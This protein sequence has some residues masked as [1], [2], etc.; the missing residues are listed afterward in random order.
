[1]ILI[2]TRLYFPETTVWKVFRRLRTARMPST[3]CFSTTCRS[4]KPSI[5]PHSARA[6][7]HGK[8]CLSTPSLHPRWTWM[9]AITV[10]CSTSV[11]A[12]TTKTRAQTIAAASRT[13]ERPFCGWD[14]RR[15]ALRRSHAGDWKRSA[16]RVI[17]WMATRKT[18]RRPRFL[19][20]CGDWLE[21]CERLWDK[22]VLIQTMRKFARVIKQKTETTQVCDMFCIFV[23]SQDIIISLIGKPL[24]LAVGMKWKML[25]LWIVFEVTG[26]RFMALYIHRPIIKLTNCCLIV[27]VNEMLASLKDSVSS[28]RTTVF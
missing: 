27:L 23:L 4:R 18:T 26:W 8:R 15:L 22:T 13:T 11:I 5:R 7:T 3:A 1:M 10:W 20:P 21:R 2:H 12:L 19:L 28:I 14:S 25:Y 17:A 24:F 9:K 6:N 16:A